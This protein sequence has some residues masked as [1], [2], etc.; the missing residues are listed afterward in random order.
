VQAVFPEYGA[1][2]DIQ[3]FANYSSASNSWYNNKHERQTNHQ[4]IGSIT[5]TTGKWTLKG[6]AEFRV[7]LSNYTDFQ[8]AAAYMQPET[9]D[10]QYITAN[11][12]GTAQDINYLQGGSGYA[13]MLEG[14]GGW[15]ISSTFSPHPA[16]AQKYFGIYTQ[17]DFH[18]TSRLT[19]NLGLRWEFQPGPTDRFNRA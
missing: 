15:G 14:A 16:L 2:P 18:A 7:D 9:Y 5:K 3:G 17:N 13:D 6:G 1:A 12:G 4:V 19:L 8:N 10:Y 11:G